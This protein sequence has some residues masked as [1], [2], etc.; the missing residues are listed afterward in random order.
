MRVSLASL[1]LYPDT[2]TQLA[3]SPINICEAYK[4]Y[5]QEKNSECPTTVWGDDYRSNKQLVTQM[6]CHF[7]RAGLT[8]FAAKAALLI[9]GAF[10]A[11]K[12]NLKR[13][14]PGMN[15]DIKT[16]I[17]KPARPIC[18]LIPTYNNEQTVNGVIDDVLAFGLDVIVVNDGSTDST[19]EILAS[20]PGIQVI[21]Y[22]P[23]RGKGIALRT[24]LKYAA[25]TG[26]DYAITIDSDGQ[27][28]AKDIPTFIDAIEKNPGSLLI[29]ARNM[30]QASVPG[31][32]SFGNKFSSFWFWVETGIKGPD[33]Q[34]GYRLYPVQLLKNS[35]FFTRKF[36]FEIEVLVNAAWKGI[37][38]RWVPVTVYYAPRSQRV[39][40]FR[41]VRDFTRVGVVHTA[42]TT[43]ALL[44]IKPRDFIRGLFNKK[45]RNEFIERHLLR[46]SESDTIKTLSIAFGLFMGIVPIW[47]FQ[48]AV[49]IPL[50]FLFRLNRAMVIL[51]ANIS[52]PPM[53]PL[54][55]FLSYRMGAIW[56]GEKA[57]F[58][59][60]S[61]NLT[62]QQVKQNIT[63]YLW[64]SVTLA[65]AAAVIGAVITWVLIKLSK[66]KNSLAA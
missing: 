41:P 32:S 39:S 36:E 45:K 6:N 28:F 59:P 30:N 12:T 25:D 47:G 63:Q 29:G 48:L 11:A 44:Y 37:P 35:R 34:S 20:K 38:I 4:H 24:G 8:T 19:P 22:G 53:I 54:I 23:N 60:F 5:F 57:T 15:N 49:A 64:G 14:T 33:T 1:L 18:I 65:I 61:T 58:L 7:C 51:A 62:L 3:L 17:T 52:L 2:F 66:K 40:H 21:S 31:K 56:M 26:Y 50:A 9:F 10:N 55:L 43:I 13:P 27:H 46:P 42:A 16:T